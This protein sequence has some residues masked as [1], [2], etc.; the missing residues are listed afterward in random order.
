MMCTAVFISCINHG[1]RG[2][3]FHCSPIENKSGI[4]LLGISQAIETQNLVLNYSAL[5]SFKMQ[6]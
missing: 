1:K 3:R 4:I 2:I 6:F 5:L